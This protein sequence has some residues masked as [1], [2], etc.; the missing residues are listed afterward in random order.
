M[1][2]Y[3]EMQASRGHQEES[4]DMRSMTLNATRGKEF[5]NFDKEFWI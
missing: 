3:L 4:K 5:E 1:Q 2:T